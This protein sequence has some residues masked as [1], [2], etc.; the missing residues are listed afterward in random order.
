MP[1]HNVWVAL[2]SHEMGNTDATFHIYQDNEIL[3]RIKIS[4]GGID[5]YPK[6]RKVPKSM[7][8]TKFDSVFKEN[9]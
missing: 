5:W 3:G 7:S 9:A 8:W 1:K 6:N 4:K 2:P